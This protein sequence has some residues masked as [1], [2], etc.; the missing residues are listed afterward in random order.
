MICYLQYSLWSDDLLFY[1]LWWSAIL[2]IASWIS[3]SV[4]RNDFSICDKNLLS[5]VPTTITNTSSIVATEG[6][7]V[8]LFCQAEGDPMPGLEFGRTRTG[9]P[10]LRGD[11]VSI[12]N[13]DSIYLVTTQKFSYQILYSLRISV[14]SDRTFWWI[15]LSNKSIYSKR[16]WYCT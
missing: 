15:N 11:N 12:V 13:R 5:A 9:M 7:S 16:Q 3:A 1:S 10:Y 14:L 8:T 6:E 4:L 2:S